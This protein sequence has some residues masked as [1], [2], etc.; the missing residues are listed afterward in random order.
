MTATRFGQLPDGSDVLE[1]Q[2][3]DGELTASI[4]TF[5]GVIR[6]IRLADIDHPLVLGFDDLDSYYH[7]SP[8]FGALVGRT[9]NRTAGGRL[10]IGDK[11]HQLHLNE[12][13]RTHL[14][15]GAEGFGRQNWRLVEHDGASVT[16][17]L[18]SEDGHQ[19][20]PG[21]VE[22]TCRYAIKAPGSL[23]LEA[24][25]VTDA[26]TAVNLAQHSYFNLDAAASILDHEVQIF[27]DAYTPVDDQRIPTGEIQPVAGTPYDFRK[28]RPI[29]WAHDGQRFAYDINMVIDRSKA[30]DPRPLARLRSPV[31]GVELAVHSTEPGVQFY[32]G[33]MMDV[34]VP[35]LGGRR[36]DVCSGVCFE[37]QLFPDAPNQPDFPTTLLSPGET[38]RQITEFAFT[39]S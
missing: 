30:E 38:Y 24:I 8:F 23:I 25:A 5:G 6:D 31:N 21:R 16:L 29:R 35:G 2:I 33:N 1:V 39:R 34:K 14:H 3:A 32:D 28:P 19:G 17:G 7:H 11:V 12:A 9:A 22:V 10:E 37:P 4:I 20:Y 13:G 36:Y 26:P 27:A 15:G 18:V